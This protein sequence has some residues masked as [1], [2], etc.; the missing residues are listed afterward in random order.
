MT[1]SMKSEVRSQESGV[2]MAVN[3]AFHRE[4]GFTKGLARDIRSVHRH[5]DDEP[6]F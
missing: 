5:L 4:A 1:A 3:V 6:V 2:R